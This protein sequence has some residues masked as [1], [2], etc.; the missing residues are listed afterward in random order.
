MLSLRLRHKTRKPLATT[1]LR[2]SLIGVEK[3]LGYPIVH[4]ERV[5]TKHS[6]TVL[7]RYQ[8]R[9]TIVEVMAQLRRRYVLFT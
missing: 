6:S 9:A 4:Q 3:G 8:Q 7:L 2:D 1:R 5:D